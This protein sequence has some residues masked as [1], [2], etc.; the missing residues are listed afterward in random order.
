MY[1]RNRFLELGIP[2]FFVVVVVVVV[3]HSKTKSNLR[4]KIPFVL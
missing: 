3:I 2:Y 4:K 1:G